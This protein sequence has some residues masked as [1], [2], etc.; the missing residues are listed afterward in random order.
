[1]KNAI[2]L[3]LLFS[4]F[5][6]GCDDDG[7]T[8][9]TPTTTTT[10]GPTA[11]EFELEVIDFGLLVSQSSGNLFFVELR[12]E[13]TAGVGGQINFIRLDYYTATGDR[14]ERAEI[15]ASDINA[16]LGSNDIEANSTW[17]E[18]P[19]FFF[20]ASIKKGRQLVVTVSITD[21]RGNRVELVES[22]IIT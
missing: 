4:L 8:T 2:P 17:Q 14:E 7:G 11:G 9:P 19:V 20:R 21:D 10:A 16:E 15:G 3:L 1:V 22:F 18:V 6:A 12:I 5:A 13:E